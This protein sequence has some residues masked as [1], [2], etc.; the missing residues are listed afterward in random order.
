[1]RAVSLL[2]GGLDSVLAT[3]VIL[4]QG[5]DVVALNCVTVF[6]TCTPKS[7]SCSA[8][9]TAV[10]Q[11]GIELKTLSTS[12]EFLNV[13][14]NPKHG[15][16]SNLNPCLDCRILMF[17]KAYE[18]MLETGA[19]FIITGEVLGERPMSQRR[20]AMKLI[21]KEAKLE[22]LIVR[23]L[24]AGLL[25]PSIPEKNGWVD[26]IRLLSISGRS[27]KPQIALAREYGINDYPCPAGGCL[28]TDPGFAARMWDLLRYTPEFSLS[29][30][31]L[32]KRGR[33]F[34]LPAGTK[35]VIGRSEEE[36]WSI[37]HAVQT[38]DMLLLPGGDV[39]GPS[40]LCSG[41][42]AEQELQIAAA[43]LATYTKKR[44]PYMDIEVRHGT[45]APASHILKA[46]EP[47]DKE[48]VAQW[49]IGAPGRQ[50]SK[51]QEN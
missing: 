50:A 25:E 18:Y 43:L 32:L 42:E 49:L 40:V 12:K 27:R 4:D 14:K 2:S 29:D 22:G 37:E 3:K 46:V 44:G 41:K 10:E 45:N 6:C 11:L 34:R 28:L 21:E 30:V 47:L 1:M 7:S 48:L 20:E 38:D 5:V 33:H 17:R 39:P 36:N 26:R 19:A 31:Q 24:S 15:Y 8:A 23:P 16:G 13:V 51:T 9:R 35:V